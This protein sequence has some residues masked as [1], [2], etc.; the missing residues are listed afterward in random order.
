VQHPVL[1][2]P[3]I[4]DSGP[5]HWQTVWEA[6]HP[7]FRRVQQRDWNRPACEEWVRTLDQEVMSA[8]PGVVLV[9]HSLACLATAHWAIRCKRPIHGALLVAIPDPSGSAFPATATGFTPLPLKRLGFPSVVVSST[10]DPYGSPFFS[11]RCA[12]AWGGRFVSIGAAGHVNAESGLGGWPQ[13]L[14]LL[15]ELIKGRSRRH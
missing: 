13:G 6:G 15:Q 5:G 9:A 1:I 10:D 7:H 11:Q 14:D 8:E 12:K 2:L 4:G 3:G